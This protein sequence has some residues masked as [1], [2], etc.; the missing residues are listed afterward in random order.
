[1]ETVDD[2]NVMEKFGEEGKKRMARSWRS[3]RTEEIILRREISEISRLF[4][5]ELWC[6]CSLEGQLNGGGL[7]SNENQE[8][9][10]C[11][12]LYKS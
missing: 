2:K 4:R 9:S 10:T 1:M 3:E 6:L 5:K 7:Q 11:G 8:P 12:R